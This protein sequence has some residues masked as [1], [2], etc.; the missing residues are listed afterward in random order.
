MLEAWP[1]IC[2]FVMTQQGSAPLYGII[3]GPCLCTSSAGSCLRACSMARAR[4]SIH[5]S[6]V[7][8]M[9][10]YLY[11]C[12]QTPEASDSQADQLVLYEEPWGTC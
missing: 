3:S 11:A 7:W 10:G 8:F 4:D 1:V 5:S 6:L 12:L 2:V 9:L